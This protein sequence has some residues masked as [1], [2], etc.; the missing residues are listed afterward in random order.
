A[1]RDPGAAHGAARQDR[2]VLRGAPDADAPA[3]DPRR[4]ELG[5]RR[6]GRRRFLGASSLGSFVGKR[7]A[8]RRVA[9]CRGSAVAGRLT[10]SLVDPD[11][12]QDERVVERDL[13]ETVVPT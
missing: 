10:A 5:S 11:F 8:M 2:A 13:L 12:L 9:Y 7:V 6:A 1:R 3:R 4:V